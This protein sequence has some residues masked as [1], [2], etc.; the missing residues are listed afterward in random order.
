MPRQCFLDWLG[1]G[2][3]NGQAISGHRVASAPMAT[4]DRHLPTV[5]VARTPKPGREREF[6]RWLARLAAGARDAPGHVAVDV[7]PPDDAHPDEWVIVYQFQDVASL[8]GWLDS[9][10]RAALVADGRDL[11]EGDEREQVLALAEDSGAVT[12]VASFRIRP[13][14]EHRAGEFHARL[15]DVLPGFPGYLRCDLFEPVAG[16]QDDVAVVFSFDSREHL[17][18]WFR[19][20]ERARLLA[21][22]AEFIDGSRTVNVVGGFGGWFSG[23]GAVEP[24]RWKQAAVVLLALYPTALVL[25]AVRRWLLPDVHWSV[26]VLIANVFGVIILSWLLMP[27]LT[28]RLSGWLRR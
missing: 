28:S 23:G 7:Q 19:S 2:T 15:L 11:L 17:D 22:V 8:R 20:D 21:E 10:R 13:G 3:W 4:P 24:R 1:L 25:T 26:A 5:V 16:V 12:A 9:P 18:A 14:E 27:W 6:E